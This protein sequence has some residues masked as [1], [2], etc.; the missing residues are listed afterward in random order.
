LPEIFGASFELLET[1]LE[2]VAELLLLFTELE[3]LADELLL[4]TEL[5]DLLFEL[6]DFSDEELLSSEELLLFTNCSSQ[7][8]FPL[9]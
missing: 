6:L 5:E 1:E 9:Q 8:F 2:D 4:L 7:D 3:D